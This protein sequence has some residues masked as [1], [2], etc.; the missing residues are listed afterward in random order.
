MYSML[1]TCELHEDAIVVFNF[2]KE[3][4]LC[5]AERQVE[6]LKT[7]KETVEKVM[8]LKKIFKDEL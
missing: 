5:K 4:P 7:D 8:L 6:V 2:T 1:K 3:C